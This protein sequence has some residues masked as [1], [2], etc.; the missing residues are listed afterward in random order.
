M[1]SL[2]GL[3]LLIGGLT[4][5]GFTLLWFLL[6]L[7]GTVGAKL[8]KKFGTDNEDT[9]KH[10]QQGENLSKSTFKKL[11]IELLVAGIGFLIWWFTK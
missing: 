6:S 8:S 11:L 1:L 3:V 4:A 2:I 5:G 7:S 9:D 10:I